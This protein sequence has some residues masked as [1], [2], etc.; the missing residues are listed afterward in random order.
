MKRALATLVLILS[1]PGAL[2]C[3]LGRH[4]AQPIMIAPEQAG[5]Q[6]D[7]A[8]D[9]RLCQQNVRDAAPKTI[10]PQWL[11]PLAPTS[12][13]ILGTVD[14]PHP[15]WPSRQAYHQAIDRCL[16]ARGYQIQGWE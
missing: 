10:Q 1:I 2:S 5:G 11:P 4:L 9:L 12:G 15:A 6:Y 13:V 16:M 14:A 7:A 8:R 3:T